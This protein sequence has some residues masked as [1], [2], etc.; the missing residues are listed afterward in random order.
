MSR[1]FPAEWEP[2]EATLLTWPWDGRIWGAEHGEAEACIARAA[3]LVCRSERV[4]VHVP[5]EEVAHRARALIETLS[6]GAPLERLRFVVLGSD[7]V[8]VRDHGPTIVLEGNSRVAIDWRFNAWGGKFPHDR[9]AHVAR[10]AA[11]RLGLACEVSSIVLEGGALE[12]DGEG[13]VLCTR[14]VALSDTRNPAATEADVERELCARLGARRIVWL[15][16]GMGCD[17]TDGHVDTLARFVPGGDVLVHVMEDRDHPDA[18]AMEENA[19]VLDASLPGRVVRLPAPT[20]RDREGDL[21]PASYANFYVANGCVLV[22]GYGAPGD[23]RARDVIGRCFPGRLASTLDCRA[24]VTQGGAIHCA[25]Q[26][27]PC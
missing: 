15:D 12:T 11:G 8:W 3:G 2:H 19:R 1:R 21:L 27:V 18:E 22:P 7:D 6:P 25:T 24:L 5:D 23:E 14:S 20:I 16:R 13:T 17:D 4:E 26:Q 9:D 10:A